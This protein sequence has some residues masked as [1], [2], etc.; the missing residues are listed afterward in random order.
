MKC[1]AH[2]SSFETRLAEVARAWW[3]SS[4]PDQGFFKLSGSMTRQSEETLPGTKNDEHLKNIGRM[5]EEMENRMRDSLQVRAESRAARVSTFSRR[6]VR[7][8]LSQ[9][10]IRLH[11]RMRTHTHTH[12][13]R[14]AHTMVPPTRG[15]CSSLRADR[16]LRENEDAG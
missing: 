14:T 4:L 3:Q 13:A 1:A 9:I 6:S 10:G 11:L 5:L 8:I 7:H 12:T 2:H 16:L 15:T